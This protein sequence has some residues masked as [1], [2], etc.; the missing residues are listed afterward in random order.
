MNGNTHE[1][2]IESETSACEQPQLEPM[3]CND[4]MPSRKHGIHE[5]LN[6]IIERLNKIDQ[7][8]AAVQYHTQTIKL[9][10]NTDP[11][12]VP[13]DPVEEGGDNTG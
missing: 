10:R 12:E 5:L 13:E 3:Q 9:I 6:Q 11:E 4:A 8:L 7:R 1:L 2:T